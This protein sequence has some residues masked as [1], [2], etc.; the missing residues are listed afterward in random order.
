[1]Y[2]CP[3][4]SYSLD[5]TKASNLED[6]RKELEKPSDAIK[7]INKDLTKY[8]PLFNKE[9]LYSDKKF[10]KLNDSDKSKVEKIFNQEFSGGQ[11]KCNNCNYT[12]NINKTIILYKLEKGDES[13]NLITSL[14]DNKMHS[15]DPALPR[16]KDYTCK[17][18][19]CPTH[20]DNK[21]KEAVYYRN[22]NT[23]KLYYIC[24]VCNFN[25]KI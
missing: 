25:W 2:F 20:K 12:K 4:C 6:N 16:T 23:Y 21:I 14:E 22:K 18:L 10:K 17:N 8:K 13:D 15:N 19:D 11:F 7:R 5:I 9:S 1:M 24:T 3:E